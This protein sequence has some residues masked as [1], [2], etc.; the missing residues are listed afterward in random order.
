MI[1]NYF[2]R[3]GRAVGARP[4]RAPPTRA[5]VRGTRYVYVHVASSSRLRNYAHACILILRMYVDVVMATIKTRHNL[6]FMARRYYEAGQL[7]TWPFAGTG[8]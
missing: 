3:I 2:G 8:V 6:K 7:G 1:N 4:A 5:P